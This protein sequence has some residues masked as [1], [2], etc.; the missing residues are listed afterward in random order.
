MDHVGIDVHKRESQICILTPEGEMVERRIQS[1]RQHFTQWFAGR[2]RA[3]VLLE[4]ATESAWVAQTLEGFGHEVIVAD[5]NYAPMYPE[6]R[7]RVKTDRR[8][9]RMLAEAARLG[10]YRPAHRTSA[11]QRQVRRQLLVRDLL[12][13]ARGRTIA[14]VR[15]LVRSEG[16]RVRAGDADK[17]GTYVSALELPDLKGV[18][19]F[20]L[21]IKTLPSLHEI[22]EGRVEV[23]Q[24]R[25]LR[26]QDLLSRARV[27]LD[28]EPVKRMVNGK[29]VMVTGA[30]GSIGSEL[31]R[32][33]LAHCPARL[34]LFERSENGLYALGSEF[35]DARQGATV[36][37]LVGDV[38]NRRS[39]D[40]AVHVHRPHIVFHAAA[41]K[42]VPLMETAPC[43]AVRNNVRGTRLML[44]AAERHG[45]ERFVL[46]STDKAVNPTS[47]MGATKRVAELMVQTIPAT[48]GTWCY[49]VRFGNVL[50]SSGSVLPRFMAQVERGGPVTITHPDVRRYFMLIPEAVE[51]VLHAAAE[52]APSGIYVLEMGEQMPV[53][54]LARSVIRLAGFV[55]DEDIDIDYVGLRPGEKLSE[56][57]VGD[58]ESTEPSTSEHMLRIRPLRLPDR[59][60]LAQQVEE[61]ERR[62]R[63]GDA[64]GVLEGL[65]AILP[66]YRTAGAGEATGVA[67]IAE[68]IRPS[69]EV[70]ARRCPACGSRAVH[71]SR[72]RSRVEPWRKSLRKNRPHRCHEC[73]WRGWMSSD[74]DGNDLDGRQTPLAP[75]GS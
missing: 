21:P 24:I 8:D 62:A 52:G 38:T 2:A 9:A 42:H 48:S 12:V 14:L 71:R 43:E 53:V 51:L 73:G 72:V 56:E 59:A 34:I 39:V 63:D 65:R 75:T 16:L 66:S 55:P 33:I 61:L 13:R 18:E 17:F 69:D 7:R 45:V 70:A 22:V 11:A 46:I 28:A 36:H 25:D 30:G 67:P 58:E 10:S 40:E 23:S 44:E 15:T 68:A 27:S 4:A 50:A 35:E 19:R 60:T 31:C 3:R 57:L 64:A 41:H 6:R 37:A 29:R 74:V 47:V 54:D 20:R 32:Q 26:P 49:G 5:P 1:T